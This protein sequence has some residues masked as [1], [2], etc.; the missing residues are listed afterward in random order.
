M[1]STPYEELSAIYMKIK[2]VVCKLF[3]FGRVQT[4]LFGKGLRSEGEDKRASLRVRIL[5]TGPQQLFFYG[6]PKTAS[7]LAEPHSSVSSIQVLRTEGSWFDP[8]AWQ[9]YFRGLMLVIA[10]GLVPLSSLSII[11][12][13]LM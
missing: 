11:S 4:L 8:Q 1:F 6:F 5:R 3:Q 2:I 12:A 9:F 13:M 7:H 10:I